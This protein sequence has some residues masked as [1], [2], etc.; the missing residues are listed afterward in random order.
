MIGEQQLA[1]H[2]YRISMQQPN[3]DD[4]IQLPSSKAPAVIPTSNLSTSISSLFAAGRP[5][6]FSFRRSLLAKFN[7]MSR[8][9]KYII[10]VVIVLT[11]LVLVMGLFFSSDSERYVSLRGIQASG[12][13][14]P[15]LKLP[16]QDDLDAGPTNEQGEG[17]QVIGG[18]GD[19]AGTLENPQQK[20]KK[21]KRKKTVL[22]GA[23]N[24]SVPSTNVIDPKKH[25]N[26]SIHSSSITDDIE[27]VG[28]Q[29]DLARAIQIDGK[30]ES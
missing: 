18:E 12:E 29:P 19:D 15:T 21:G 9:K 2:S 23:S 4:V 8:G 1:I 14:G 7:Q 6:S 27:K 3:L 26:F 25:H 11:L 10:V 30:P 17:I 13:R 28:E 5:A 20:S 22:S 24:S 16:K